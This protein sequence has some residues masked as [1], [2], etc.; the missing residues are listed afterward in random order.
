MNYRD[1]TFSEK[2]NIRLFEKHFHESLKNLGVDYLDIF[3]L[4]MVGKKEGVLF[5][6][7]MKLMDRFKKE[8]KTR[9]LGIASHIHVAEAV[10]AAADSGL[11]DVVMPAF[12]FQMKNIGEIEEAVAYAAG[13]GMGVV[14]MKTVIGDSWQEGRK[15]LKSD[16]KAALKWVFRNKNIHTA[17]P[18][19]SSY[20]EMET[21]L[22]VMRDFELTTEEKMTLHSIQQEDAGGLICQG[23]ASCLEQCSKAPDIPTLMRSYMYAYGY[24][25]RDMALQALESVAERNIPCS[26][27][28]SCRINCPMGFDIKTKVLEMMKLKTGG[29]IASSEK[30]F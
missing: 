8:G 27:C 1:G 14:A 21:D 7:F 3:Y 6:P 13:K 10:R 17:V 24:H 29:K 25:N 16:P 30:P 23:C 5:E 28:A 15:H 26:D 2:T 18:G 4:P 12:N 20:E 22:S 11:Y 19:F 9:F